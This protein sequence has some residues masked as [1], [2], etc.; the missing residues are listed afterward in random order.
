MNE[1]NFSV[2]TR[3]SNSAFTTDIETDSH[4]FISD[5][6]KEEGGADKG[7]TPYDLLVSALGACT[8]MTLQLYAK[9]KEMDLKKVTVYLS[10]KKIHAEDCLNCEV[11][12]SKLD[13]ISR[14]IELEGNLT[15]DQKNRLIAIADKCPVSKTLAAGVR[16]ETRLKIKS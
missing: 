5:E 8:G 7:P 13:V 14:E 15:E 10:H 1:K 12:D 2:V 6:P 9:H 16:I 4:T 11:V 3:T